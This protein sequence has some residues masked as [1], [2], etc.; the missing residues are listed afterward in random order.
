MTDRCKNITL[1]TTSLLPVIISKCA[2]AIKKWA[3][4]FVY[5]C[6]S[7][8]SDLPSLKTGLPHL[9]TKP[10]SEDGVPVLR[11][12]R[13]EDGVGGMKMG[14]GR[15]MGQVIQNICF[16]NIS[17]KLNFLISDNLLFS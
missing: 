17:V 13:S 8:F 5:I 12:G 15:K 1:A 6:C 11:P 9:P 2:L 7:P 4:L 16:R 10:W 14:Q 3:L